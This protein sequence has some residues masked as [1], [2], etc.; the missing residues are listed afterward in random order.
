MS[1]VAYALPSFDPPAIRA[2]SSAASPV[3]QKI[4]EMLVDITAHARDNATDWRTLANTLIEEIA[5]DCQSENWDGYGARPIGSGAKEQAQRFVD[6]LPLR[7]PAPQPAADPDGE[8]AL[9]WDLGPGHVL[10]VNIGAQGELTYA[11]LLGGGIKR[12]GVERFQ[13]EIP[14]TILQS[15]D[16]LCEHAGVVA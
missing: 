12:H 7:L 15:I 4:S 10:T 9:T 2:S 5:R 13:E 6:L 8:L 3:G 11:G 1:A 16:E 14:R